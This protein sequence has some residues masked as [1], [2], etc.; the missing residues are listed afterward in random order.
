[1]ITRVPRK[2]RNNGIGGK[3]SVLKLDKWHVVYVSE[4]DQYAMVWTT[5]VPRV[6]TES[7]SGPGPFESWAEAMAYAAGLRTYYGDQV[8]GDGTIWDA[9]VGTGR[10]RG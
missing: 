7:V 4:V 10:R 6:T 2:P 8:R 9:R 1:M 3:L 5:T